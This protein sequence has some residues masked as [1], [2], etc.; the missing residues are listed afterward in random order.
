MDKK[1]FLLDKDVYS[2]QINVLNLTERVLE[3]WVMENDYNDDNSIIKIDANDYDSVE[4]ALRNEF[5]FMDANDYFVF[6]FNF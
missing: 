4:D 6:P 3:E 1:I 5:P 2:Q